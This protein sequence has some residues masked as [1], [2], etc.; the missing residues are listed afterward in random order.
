MGTF[1]YP[2]PAHDVRF[3]LA[4]FDQPKAAIFQVM[5]FRMSYFNDPWI[6]SSPSALMEGVG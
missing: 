1:D 6:L 2:L 3:I 4:V 5:F